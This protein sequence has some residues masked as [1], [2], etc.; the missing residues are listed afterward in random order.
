MPFHTSLYKEGLGVVVT[1]FCKW[2]P[3]AWN[4]SGNWKK[5]VLALSLLVSE[6]F[7]CYKQ[8]LDVSM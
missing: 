4:T 1:T 2:V 3:K 8:L 7:Q 5:S 6:W